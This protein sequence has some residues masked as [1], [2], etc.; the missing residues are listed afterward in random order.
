VGHRARSRERRRDDRPRAPD[1]TSPASAAPASNNISAGAPAS[2]RAARLHPPEERG[3]T[4]PA[5]TSS[6]S[7]GGGALGAASFFTTGVGAGAPASGVFIIIDG[8]PVLTV[9]DALSFARYTDGAILSVRRDVSQ[10]P[11]VYEASERL[12]SVGMNVTGVVV[13]GV[14]DRPSRAMYAMSLSHHS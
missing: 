7:S 12:K 10:I 9:A 6:S 3:A 4:A 13:N 11:K 2:E 5:S 8:A 14:H 1:R